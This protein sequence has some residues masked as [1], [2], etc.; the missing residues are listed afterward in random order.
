MIAAVWL[1]ILAAPPAFS[2]AGAEAGIAAPEPPTP[3]EAVAAPA[4]VTS[5]APEAAPDAMPEAVAEAPAEPSAVIDVPAQKE[6]EGIEVE[7]SASA[8][9]K[10]SVTLDNVPLQDVVRMFTRISGA[11]IVS[12][13]NLSG[14][15]TVNLQEVEWEPAL[16]VILDST[17][18]ALLEKSPGIYTIVSKSE[19]AAEPVS[20]DTIFLSYA[21]ISNILPLVQSMLVSTNASVA[22]FPGANALIVQETVS[23]I[24]TIREVVARVDKPRDQVLIEAKF[25]ELNDEAIKDLGINWQVLEGY[26][27]SVTPQYEY[28]K[29]RNKNEVSTSSSSDRNQRTITDRLTRNDTTVDRDVQ[30]DGSVAYDSGLES[31]GTSASFPDGEVTG[32]DGSSR[33]RGSLSVRGENFSDF[34]AEE[35]RLTLIPRRDRTLTDTKFNED[36]AVR[37]LDGLISD[38]SSITKDTTEVLSAILS[39]EQFS[40]TLSAL[41]QNNGVEIVSNPKV[42]VASGETANIH[43]GRNEPNIVAVPQGDTGDRYAYQLD[44]TTPFIE[45]GVKLTVTPTLNTES[46]INVRIMPELSRK[47][48]DKLVGEAGTSYPVTQIRKINTEFNLESGRT[49]A[50]GGLTE[51][52]DVES[53]VKI[54]VLGDIPIIGKYLFRHTHTEKLQDEVIIFVTVSSAKP[55]TLAQISGIPEE[56]RLIHRHLAQRAEE[57]SKAE[58]MKARKNKSR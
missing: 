2:Q 8:D 28:G 40:L 55:S 4:E 53:V 25:V 58:Q 35:N 16:R 14:N 43:V 30:Q 21:T 39:A 22:G 6:A 27:L 29:T 54:P 49:V 32:S 24:K 57:A 42:V 36:N 26:T 11:N 1:A 44:D 38:T 10:I 5:A 13:T 31:S 18:N 9:N 45:I 20:S 3:P 47:L 33:G 52:D 7:Q 12:G 48:A 56:G 37:T 46:N 19:L 15:V 23:R 34:D 17:G 51:T 50:I 41:K